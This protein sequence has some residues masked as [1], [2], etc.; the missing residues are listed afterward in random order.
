M[1]F[2]RPRRQS[3][4]ARALLENEQRST[5]KARFRSETRPPR[6]LANELTLHRILSVAAKS[7]PQSHAN[8]GRD[9]SQSLAASCSPILRS[10]LLVSS[11][12]IKEV[13]YTSGSPE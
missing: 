5:P 11:D 13:A 8:A 6:S 4:A 9:K 3:T 10:L 2:P 1:L 7:A 12:Q